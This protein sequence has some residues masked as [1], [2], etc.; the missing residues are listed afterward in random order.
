MAGGGRLSDGTVSEVCPLFQRPDS[1]DFSGFTHAECG[2]ELEPF[3]PFGELVEA[4]AVV[5]GVA[6]G[7]NFDAVCLHPFDVGEVV[8]EFKVGWDAG[9]VVLGN[10]DLHALRGRKFT[11]LVVV[12][13][14]V[15]FKVQPFRHV[16][17]IENLFKKSNALDGACIGECAAV[18]LEA[19]GSELYC[20]RD[21]LADSRR[22]SLPFGFVKK[23]VTDFEDVA[24]FEVN[25]RRVE[26]FAFGG[27]KRFGTHEPD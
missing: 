15:A 12:V 4:R 6:H 1:A 10:E 22:K 21:E 26:F 23:V 20:L 11:E 14:A 9:E 7:G 13:Q 16:R 2:D 27:G 25:A 8:L 24:A 3:C 5:F 19:D 17:C 18:T